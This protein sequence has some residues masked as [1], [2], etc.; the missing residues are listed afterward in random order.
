METAIVARPAVQTDTPA[1]SLAMARAFYDDPLISWFIPNDAKR[2]GVQQRMYR[3]M[4]GAAMRIGYAD[5]YTT[6]DAVGASLWMRPGRFKPPPSA[7]LPLLASALRD[8]RH[9]K[10]GRMMGAMQTIEKRHPKDRPHWYLSGIG[11]DPAH[12]RR[13]IATA[14]MAAVLQRCDSERVPAYLETQKS[15][16]VPFYEHR[17]FTVTGELDL[18]KGGPHLWLMWRDP[19]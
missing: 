1:I 15:Q 7:M 16:N 17:G 19:A 13:G 12:Q 10:V 11:T 18:P 4:F 9:V 8:V 5:V 6:P 2:M 3:A 14:L